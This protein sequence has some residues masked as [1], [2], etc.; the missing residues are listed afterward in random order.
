MWI[1]RI[2]P[3]A[4]L[5]GVLGGNDQI[6]REAAQAESKA[7]AF[8][9]REVPAWSKE[10][11][12][13]SCHNNGDAARALYAASSKGYRVPD[14]ALADTTEWVKLPARWDHNKGDPGFSDKRLADIQFAGSLLAAF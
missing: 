3:L 10:N 1:K 5:T 6:N 14:H 9:T 13:F 7:V 2:L 8:L 4:A 11:G 12:C